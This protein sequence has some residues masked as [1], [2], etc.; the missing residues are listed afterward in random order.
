M[1]YKALELLIEVTRQANGFFQFYEPWKEL[2]DRKVAFFNS[3]YL[4]P[5]FINTKLFSI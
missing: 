5:I 4:T 2:D 1:I 3:I